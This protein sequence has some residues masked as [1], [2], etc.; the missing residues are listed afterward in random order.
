MNLAVSDGRLD[1]DASTGAGLA[2]SSSLVM[3][4]QKIKVGPGV[5]DTDSVDLDHHPSKQLVKAEQQS[6][7]VDR[8]PVREPVP[9]QQWPVLRFDIHHLAPVNRNQDPMT[10]AVVKVI[11]SYSPFEMLIVDWQWSGVVVGAAV[12]VCVGVEFSV[13]MRS[14]GTGSRERAWQSGFPPVSLSVLV[15][16]LA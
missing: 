10:G 3:L 11:V 13:V 2:D 1:A 14:Q 8:W 9:V 6:L 15:L 7:V 16:V 5:A 12:V 4:N